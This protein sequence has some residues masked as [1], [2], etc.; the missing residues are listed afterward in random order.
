VDRHHS[1]CDGSLPS[2]TRARRW[3]GIRGGRLTLTG[4][5]KRYPGTTAVDAIDLDVASGEFVTLLGPSGSGKTTTLMMVAG[6]TPP[7][8]GEIAIDGRPITGIAPEHRNLGVVFQNYALFPHMRVFDNVAFPL[9]MRRQPRAEIRMR[10]ERALDMVHLAGLGERLPRQLS[11]GQQQRV[12]LAR[13]LVFDPGLLLMD[14]PLG[15]LDRNLREQMKLEIKRIHHDLG[16]TVLYVT[17]D[18]EE[19]LTM[20]DRVALMRGGRI[21]QLG[22]AEDLY[23]RPA[24][25]FVAE[26]I[27]ESNLLEGRLEPADGGAVFVH[28]GGVRVRVAHAPRT[29]GPYTLMVRPEKVAIAPAG[30]AD[31]GVPGKVEEAIYVGEFTRYQV[32]VAPDILMTVKVPNTHAVYRAKPD[33][34]VRVHW[35]VDDGYLVPTSTPQPEAGRH[36]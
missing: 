35:A 28:R 33:D 26:F 9:R 24:S 34:A 22:S 27:G 31:D 15:A 12:A 1:G 7:S 4:L 20:S 17:H 8:E 36:E 16:V 19:A 6:F 11:G 32:R 10:V 5:T 21:A 2:T 29:G 25:R 14:E 13:A 3:R 18:Q 30:P 23:E